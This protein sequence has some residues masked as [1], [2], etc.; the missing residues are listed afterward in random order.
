MP[1]FGEKRRSEMKIPLETTWLLASCM[2]SR[3]KQD[4]WTRQ[5]PEV[6]KA[7]RAQAIVQSVES[8]NRIEGVTV[9]ANRLRPLV[10]GKARPQDLLRYR[11][12]LFFGCTHSLRVACRGMRGS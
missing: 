7:L 1:S 4:L 10:L 5:K 12:G 8:S 6:L 3:G 2:E 11:Q 9:D